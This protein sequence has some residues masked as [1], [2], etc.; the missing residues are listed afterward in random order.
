MIVV[1]ETEYTGAG[2]HLQPQLSFARENGIE[3]RFGDPEEEVPG[4][5]VIIPSHPSLIK[6]KDMDLDRQKKSLIRVNLRKYGTELTEQDY[7]YLCEETKKDMD[8]VK[9]AVEEVKAAL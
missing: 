1:Q 7:K 9:A 6:A 4:K 5:S 8:W 2:K 3:V